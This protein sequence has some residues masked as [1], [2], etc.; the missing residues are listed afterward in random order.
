MFF[1]IVKPCGILKLTDIKEKTFMKL[2][3]LNGKWN[4]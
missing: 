3:D 2:I 1:Y 4:G